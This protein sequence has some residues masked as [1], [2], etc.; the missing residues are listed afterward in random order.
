[1]KIK[2][3]E[4]YKPLRAAAY[5]DIGDQLDAVFKLVEYLHEQGFDLPAEVVHWK[6]QCRG[7]KNKFPKDGL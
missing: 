6:D 3:T 1:M 7:V 5:P 2:H 4:P